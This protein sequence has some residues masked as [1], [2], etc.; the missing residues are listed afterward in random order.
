MA[1]EE[2]KNIDLK[3]LPS[4]EKL[5]LNYYDSSVYDAVIPNMSE[6]DF[7]LERNKNYMNEVAITFMGKKI[8]YEELHT[9]IDEYAR[10]LYKKGIRQGDV[11]AL[12]VA[13]TP[14]S[15]YL[16]YSLNKLGA[17]TSP[18]NP[19]YNSYKMSRDIE[20]IKPK[21]FIGINDCYKNFKQAGKGMD[22]EMLVFP[23]VQSI[24]DKKLHFMYGAKQL[25]SGNLTLNPEKSLKRIVEIGKDFQSV[26]YGNYRSGQLDEIM[27]TGGSSGMH[28]GVDLDGNGLNAVVR[29]LDYVLCLEPGE[30]F[31]GNLPQFM[32]FGKMALHYALCKSLN[33]ELTLKAL[34]NDFVS[35]LKRVR[36]NGVMGGPVH[37]ETL[38]NANLSKDDLRDLRM[39][40]SG[41]EQLKYEKEQQI[42]EALYNAGCSSTL[43]NG[44]GMS[45]MW[46]PVSVKRGSINSDTTIGTMI[47]FTNAK[48]VDINT[49]DELGYGDVGVLHVSGP[50]MMLG[51]HNNPVETAN[52]V[53]VDNDGSR[54]FITGDL[55]KIEKNG[56]LKYVGRLKRC[57]VCGCDNIYPEQIENMLCNLPEIREA[58]VTKIPDDKMQFLPKYHISLY[59]ENCD[60]VQLEKKI[61]KMILTTLGESALPRFYEYHMEPLPRTPNGKIDPKGLQET[62]LNKL[63]S[64]VLKK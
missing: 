20:I 31:L 37:W 40:I 18:I 32:A 64:K 62:D 22:I 43:W 6:Y 29:S 58:I 30:K 10:A 49:G 47:P 11:V 52:S 55:C 44:L 57:F 54:W 5:H 59:D 28:K 23:A 9:R 7:L 42:N 46:A 16:C 25:I 24:D 63:K 61:E 38:I 35:E 12:G 19:T 45:E 41:G 48:I 2:L 3:K 14:E 56:E 1:Y 4:M 21:M 8:T 36:P 33:L 15:V 51:Y 39:P 27:F 50:G 26:Q 13:N 17:I 34:P 53:Y 60:V